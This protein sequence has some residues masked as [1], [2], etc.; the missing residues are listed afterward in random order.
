[1]II[2]KRMNLLNKVPRVVL[3]ETV[4][5]TVALDQDFGIQGG[6]ILK[7]QHCRDGKCLR[8]RFAA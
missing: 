8:L 4:K 2:V 3:L 5:F 1:M 6:L 7:V